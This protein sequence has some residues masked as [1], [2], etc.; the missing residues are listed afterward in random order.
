[1]LY[2]A[3]SWFCVRTL[4]KHEHIAAAGL[5]QVEGVEVFLPR[6]RFR[7][8]TKRGAVWFTEALFPGYLFARFDLDTLLRRVRSANGVRGLVQFGEKFA[9]APAEIV[10]DLRQR[11]GPEEL[12][13]VGNELAVGDA[14]QIS[15]GALH[16][17]RAVV[18]QVISSRE[19]VK[20]LLEFLGRA[21]ETEMAQANVVPEKRHPL[22]MR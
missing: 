12:C 6:I 20:V 22:A 10:A 5:R 1:M 16:G 2:P 13:V 19:R 8:A 4:P 7:R 9:T 17:L 3:D 21:T 15:G 11:T 18:T 14:V